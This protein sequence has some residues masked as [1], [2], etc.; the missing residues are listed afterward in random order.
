MTRGEETAL[1]GVAKGYVGDE[2]T[3]N[4]KFVS[5]KNIRWYKTGDMGRFWND[6][7]IEFLGRKDTQVK[8]RGY[9]IELG[10]I[11]AAINRAEGIKSS[12]ACI[13]SEGGSQ[14]LCAFIVKNDPDSELIQDETINQ[15]ISSYLPLYMVPS[16]Y[17]YGKS[18]PLSANGK[19][20]RKMVAELF[21]KERQA[22]A[23]Y[24]KPQGAIEEELERLWIEV[25]G[26]TKYSRDISFFKAGGDSLKA[27][28]LIDKIKKSHLVNGDLGT[29][30]LV[31]APTI[32]ELAS[33]IQMINQG[34]EL[35]IDTI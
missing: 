32:R 4:N 17:Q 16:E 9:R 7:T 26:S 12:V 31:N 10:E 35:T 11:E 3:T 23:G 8:F 18:I 15:S 14:K 27:I 22:V 1:I 34:A 28:M 33:Q 5:F 21:F 24:E 13:V 20:D 29:A 19:V 25:L 30:I 2:T 6:G